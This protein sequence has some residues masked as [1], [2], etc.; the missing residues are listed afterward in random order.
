MPNTP[1]D[2][3]SM[4]GLVAELESGAPGIAAHPPRDDLRPAAL[5]RQ[6]LR[7]LRKELRGAAIADTI[8]PAVPVKVDQLALS[9]AAIV[10]REAIAATEM[11][12]TFLLTKPFGPRVPMPDPNWE[13]QPTIC[14]VDKDIRT[15]R[16]PGLSSTM[17]ATAFLVSET[18][19]ATAKHCIDQESLPRLRF[20]FD[21]GMITATHAHCLFRRSDV[22]EAKCVR[23]GNDDWALVELDRPV[24]DR[25]PLALAGPGA[26]QVGRSVSTIGHPL[27]LPAKYSYE[28]EITR[29]GART[30][31][32]N[33][34][35]YGGSSGGP[36]FDENLE[37][38]IGIVSA[39]VPDKSSH[40]LQRVGERSVLLPAEPLFEGSATCVM[41]DEV[42]E[43]LRKWRP[44]CELEEDPPG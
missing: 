32:A 27:G 34:R 37:R 30:F 35:I 29:K 22:Y 15:H 24:A 41:L 4:Q 19:V 10:R 25:V 11:G 13:D 12:G 28:S 21:F 40:A 23:L 16:H 38:V 20:V 26:V 9:V 6:I 31:D 18:V 1:V 44:E 33:L 8:D 14:A 42:S 2:G 43:F 36:V 39:H 7:R 3:M 17:H 5:Y